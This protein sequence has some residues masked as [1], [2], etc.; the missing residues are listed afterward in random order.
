MGICT[1]KLG[2]H[3]VNVHSTVYVATQLSTVYLTYTL[4]TVYYSIPTLHTLYYCTYVG[5]YAIRMYCSDEFSVDVLTEA[6]TTRITTFYCVQI[7]TPRYDTLCSRCSHKHT[8][9]DAQDS[10]CYNKVGLSLH[11]PLEDWSNLH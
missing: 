5:G 1:H 7:F 10:H 3:T 8:Y 11:C 4:H 2:Q 6:L 9:N